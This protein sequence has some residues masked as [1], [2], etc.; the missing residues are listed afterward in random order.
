MAVLGTYIINQ[1][2]IVLSQSGNGIISLFNKTNSGKIVRIKNV[3]IQNFR[4]DAICSYNISN[5]WA[6]D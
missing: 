2:D 5:K 4:R 3:E 6:G 1:S